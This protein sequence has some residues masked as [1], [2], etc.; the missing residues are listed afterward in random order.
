[1]SFTCQSPVSH[2]HCSDKA[3]GVPPPGKLFDHG[4]DTWATVFIPLSLLSMLGRGGVW[5]VS[6][7][8][9][10][11]PCLA[12][13]GAFLVCHWEKYITGVFYLPWLYD[14]AELVGPA[15][16][17]VSC[18]CSECGPL[19]SGVSCDYALA[20]THTHTGRD[21]CLPRKFLLWH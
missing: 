19:C 8:Q 20:H 21:C 10:F 11:L 7:S 1:M 9:A 4:W 5:S 14:V 6:P 2:M 15:V 16:G 17:V 18:M 3:D 12:V 13:M